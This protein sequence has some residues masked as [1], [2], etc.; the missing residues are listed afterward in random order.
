MSEPEPINP[1]GGYR[2]LKAYE[3]AEIIYHGTA[4]L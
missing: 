2:G 4:E 3:V 1:H